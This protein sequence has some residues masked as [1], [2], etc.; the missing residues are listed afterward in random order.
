MILSFPK[1]PRN[2]LLGLLFVSPW[3]VG[4]GIFLIYPMVISAYYSFTNYNIFSPPFWTGLENYKYLFEDQM[5]RL[6]L[7]N[8]IVYS[9]IIIPLNIVMGLT[10]ALLIYGFK[11]EKVMATCVYL[12]YTLPLVVVGA[13][14]QWMYNGE[15]GIM[16]YVLELFGI[17]GPNWLTSPF[18]TKPA[19][20]ITNIFLLGPMVL[21]FLAALHKIP[22]ELYDAAKLET[23]GYFQC[24][25]HITLP[26]ISPIILFNFILQVIGVVQIFDIPYSLTAGVVSHSTP[27]G[28]LNA[29]LFY[30]MYLTEVAFKD[31]DLGYGCTLG[32]ILFIGIM[33]FTVSIIRLVRRWI[34][35]AVE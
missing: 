32:W 25:W 7:R 10:L 5:L 9:A 12:P 22:E 13:I 34:Y 4:M 8:T 20:G 30:I 28:P 23:N 29:G 3:L 27:G 16:N 14:F 2:I 6:V 35:Y 1:I 19:I 21:I 33:I 26:M 18:W 24:M 15:Y 31:F 11:W 17:S